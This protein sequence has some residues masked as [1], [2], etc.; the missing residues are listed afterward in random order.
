MS[1]AYNIHVVQDGHTEGNVVA[2]FTVKHE[3]EAWLAKQPKHRALEVTTVRDG[4]K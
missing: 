1:R 2:A 4:G 3:L